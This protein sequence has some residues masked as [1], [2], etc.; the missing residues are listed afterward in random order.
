MKVYS[1]SGWIAAGSSVNGT[2]DRFTYT[3]TANQTTFTGNDANS[4]SLA[5]DAGYLDVYM[6]GVKLVNG[7][8][9]TATN[10]TSIVLASGAAANDTIEIIA[11]GTFVLADH[12][13]KTQADARYVN[14]T[15][16][17]NVD[18]TGLVK[19][20]GAATGLVI[21]ETD[22]TDLNTYFNSNS[23]AFKLFTTNDAFSSFTERMRVDHSTGDISFYDTSGNAKFVWDASASNLGIGEATPDDTL[24]VYSASSLDHIKVDGPAGINRNV[25]FSAAGAAR[26]NIYANSTAETGSNAGSDLSIARYADDGSYIATAALIERSTGNFLVGKTAAGTATSG[27]QVGSDGFT[28]IT[29]SANPPLRIN[30]KTDD[31]TIIDIRKDNTTV[32]V[33]GSSYGD[34]INIGT[35]N[36][37]IMFRTSSRTIDPADPS[38]G[39][40]TDNLIGLGRSGVRFKDLYLAGSARI[41]G[42]QVSTYTVSGISGGSV[43]TSGGDIVTGRM[44]FTGQSDS[45]TDLFGINNE[46]SGLTIY[47]YTDGVHAIKID[48]SNN[49]GIGVSGTADR[50]LH[51]KDANH[52]TIRMDDTGGTAGGAMN[53]MV[54]FYAGG[55]FGGNVGYG[56]GGGY[57]AVNNGVGPIVF[58]T[59]NSAG[60]TTR[61]N[62]HLYASSTVFNESAADLDFRVESVNSSNMFFI[63]A[64]T[65][66]VRINNPYTSN[67]T[68]PGSLI[69]PD[70]GNQL[71]P[72]R[73]GIEF[74]TSPSSNGYAHRL[75]TFDNGAGDTPF[76]ISR[77]NNDADWTDVVTVEGNTSLTTFEGNVRIAG[78]S[79][80]NNVIGTELDIYNGGNQYWIKIFH[81]YFRAGSGFD[82]SFFRLDFSHNGATN[83]AYAFGS[84][85]VSTKQQGPT[86]LATARLFNS[87]NNTNRVAWLYSSSGGE[88]S[89]GLLEIWI[90][91]PTTYCRTSVHA[92]LNSE[93]GGNGIVGIPQATSTGSV[94]QPSG[95]SIL[96]AQSTA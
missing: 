57:M 4:N 28:G 6:N 15:H 65:N 1:A 60:S 85:A 26:W 91:P 22:T 27:F 37:G 38:T 93:Y 24:H 63:D 76:V 36:T 74:Y 12:Y 35:G 2:A 84:I 71:L 55:V 31:G 81:R 20:E 18:I 52:A 10:G 62:A 8:D 13:T 79:L 58:S 77:R 69:L 51:I 66:E 59:N 32:G 47:N 9:F 48:N 90:Q 5:Y 73:G 41:S 21:N 34:R 94:T 95:S 88:E 49:V 86:D 80:A 87:Y 30:R 43:D 82:H 11:Y 3:A 40:I 72:S 70:S 92:F 53:T 16:T 54:E 23:G 50:K 44:F 67:A 29:R 19:I 33:I 25:Q 46:S 42:T 83:N 68:Y 61:H 78:G 17:G 14:Q 39:L 75:T 45:G 89:A 56:T 96:T 64:S 7:S